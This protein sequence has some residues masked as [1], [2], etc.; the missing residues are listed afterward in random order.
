MLLSLLMSFPQPWTHSSL[1][2]FSSLPIST[3]FNFQLS[4]L[5]TYCQIYITSPN[6]IIE[7]LVLFQTFLQEFSYISPVNI[8]SI[9]L[10]IRLSLF[11]RNTFNCSGFCLSIQGY[12]I[13]QLANHEIFHSS[14]YLSNIYLIA[15]VR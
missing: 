15:I 4:L 9:M 12:T 2:V 7:F 5:C 10:Q 13:L 3:T 11:P 14:I 6:F 8:K 1:S